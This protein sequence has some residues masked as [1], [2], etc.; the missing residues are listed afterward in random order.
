MNAALAFATA[1]I[2]TLAGCSSPA[3]WEGQFRDSI[4]ADLSTET[5][6]DRLQA[7]MAMGLLGLDDP[8]VMADVI[9]QSAESDSEN[10]IAWDI[11]SDENLEKAA[12]I[13]IE[14][15]NCP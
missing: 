4:R 5:A 13:F 6:E 11:V 14:E 12:A 1:A 10:A 15:M 8:A 2:I 7:C 9:R 3:G